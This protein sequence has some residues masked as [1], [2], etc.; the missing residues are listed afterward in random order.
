MHLIQATNFHIRKTAFFFIPI[1]LLLTITTASGE[2]YSS[3]NDQINNA[4][5]KI[6]SVISSPDYYRPWQQRVFNSVGSG[7]VIN[8]KRILT[9][10]H[11]VANQ[12]FIEVRK[13]GDPHRYQAKV[14][15]VSHEA[16]L[17][18]LTVTEEGFFNNIKPLEI[19]GLPRIQ[20]EV[21]VYGFP[22]GG[23]TLSITKGIVS[24]IE[25]VQYIHSSLSFLAG[26]IDAAINVGNSGGPVISNG[27][28]VGVAMQGRN[29]ADN[30][31][32]LIPVPIIN[33][34][35]EDIKDGEYNGFP[36]L[37]LITQNMENPDMKKKYGMTTKQTG[38]MIRH[39]LPGSSAIDKIKEQD[40]ILSIDNHPIADDGTAEF[41]P[42][43]RTSYGH[44]IDMKQIGDE[45]KLSILREEKAFDLTL[46]IDTRATDLFS[47]QLEQYDTSPRYFIFG[48]I[49]FSPL[50]KKLLLEWGDQWQKRAPDELLVELGN[51]QTETQKE[52]VLA[53]H[54]L[55]ADINKG[56][57]T[58][59]QRI[60]RSVNDEPYQDFNDFYSKTVNGS[61]PYVV[62]KDWQKNQFIIDRK[63]AIASHEAILDT[64]KIPSDRF[65]AML[66]E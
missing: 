4:I 53:L 33:H 48:G 39:I 13:N 25:H 38:V 28:V 3:Q 2:E 1:I 51:L 43:E 5:I 58:I 7:F 8:D 63:K 59:A 49:V 61:E 16:D 21:L 62:F 60:I 40:I 46:K 11:V 64:Y 19:G 32:Y 56:Y 55:P 20:Q 6:Y 29:D 66:G 10:A 34:F 47:N 9:N 22:T 36:D 41:R 54:V 50:N 42:R 37:G 45:V 52:T 15:N 30:I 65:P 35:L 24:R 26:Q 31:G 17:A 14:L 57:H 18:L 44:F 27:K 12:T 23:D